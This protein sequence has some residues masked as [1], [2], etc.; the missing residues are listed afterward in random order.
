MMYVGMLLFSLGAM[1]GDSDN[2]VIPTLI[3]TA[4]ATLMLIGQRRDKDETS[5]KTPKNGH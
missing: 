5:D 2:L 4:G 3:L 1:M